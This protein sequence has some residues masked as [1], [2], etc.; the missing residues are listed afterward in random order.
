MAKLYGLGNCILSELTTKLITNN[1]FNK[2]VFYKNEKDNDILSMPNLDNPFVQLKDQI[3]KNRRPVK[4]L[5]NEDVCVFI[6]LDDVRNESARSKKIKTI[7]FRV[8]FIIHNNLSETA[9][10]MR[11][12]ALIS[13]IEKIVEQ[14]EFQKAFGQAEVERVKNLQ[15]LPYEWN[16][17]EMIVKFDGFTEKKI[18]SEV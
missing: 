1:E 14:D 18:E 16:G 17:Y 3:F 7:W 8:S 9:N 5:K 2:L 15:G 4:T 10:G 11:E 12:I 6:Y 13:A